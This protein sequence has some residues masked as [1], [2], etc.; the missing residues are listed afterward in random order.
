MA[1]RRCLGGCGAL[2]SAGSYCPRC[3]PRNGS[4]RAWRDLREQVLTRDGYTCQ[5]CGVPAAHVDHVTPV[6]AHG[7]DSLGNLRALCAA[8]NLT[9]GSR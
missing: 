1:V 2:I 9:K 3:R 5:R 4:T 8:C 7:T 6:L